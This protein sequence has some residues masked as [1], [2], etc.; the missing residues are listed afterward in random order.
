MPHKW[1]ILLII[2]FIC[3]GCLSPGGRIV[4]MPITFLVTPIEY[5]ILKI[6]SNVIQTLICKHGDSSHIG[7][8]FIYSIDY[9]FSNTITHF[10]LEC[11]LNKTAFITV[12]NKYTGINP[13][14]PKR[15]II[16]N[17]NF[18]GWI[19]SYAFL[20]CIFCML[21]KIFS[22]YSLFKLL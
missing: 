4:S 17:S 16:G 10:A 6:D 8:L 9:N 18:F 20:S 2:L 7:S 21:L 5:I 14:H 12:T 13:W 22:V 1:L 19:L 3:H 11:I 15:R